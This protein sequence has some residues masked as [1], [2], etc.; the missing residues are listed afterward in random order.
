MKELMTNLWYKLKSI[1]E[2]LLKY[3]IQLLKPIN[4]ILSK[5]FEHVI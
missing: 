1:G 3:L 4:I 5:L 2:N